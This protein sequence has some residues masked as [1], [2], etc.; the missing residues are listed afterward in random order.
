MSATANSVIPLMVYVFPLLVW[1]Y[2]KIL[3]VKRYIQRK[4]L[5]SISFSSMCTNQKK[6]WEMKLTIDSFNNRHGDFLCSIFVNLSSGTFTSVN[7][8]CHKQEYG[9]LSQLTD[10]NSRTKR[11]G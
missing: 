2:A 5:I 6:E 4:S 11:G 10:E 9:N 3:P 8:I 7:S 1:P